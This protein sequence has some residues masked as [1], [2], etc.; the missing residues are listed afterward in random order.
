MTDVGSFLRRYSPYLF[1]VI[2]A[3]WALL[4]VD[5]RSVLMA[6]PVIACALSG[7]LLKFQPGW[8]VTFSWSASTAI[9][10]L[11]ISVYQVY[12]WSPLLAGDFSALAASA[13]GVFAVLAVVHVFLLYAGTARPIQA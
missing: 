6:W 1:W 5:G 11:L 4:G 10:G 12:A 13:L 9:L 8:R 3:V 7:A 2:A